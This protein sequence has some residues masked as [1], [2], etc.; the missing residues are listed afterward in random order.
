MTDRLHSY[1]QACVLLPDA[2]HITS[3]AQNNRAENPHLTI[4]VCGLNQVLHFG[5]QSA[6]SKL[7]QDLNLPALERCLQ[8][9]TI[10]IQKWR[11]HSTPGI[12]LSPKT[13]EALFVSN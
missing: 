5:S 2:Q 4:P 13:I 8:R 7:L 6:H 1:H 9:I 12:L 10:A 11:H 3:K